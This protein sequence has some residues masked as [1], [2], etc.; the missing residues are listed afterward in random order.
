MPIINH[1]LK[2]WFVSPEPTTLFTWGIQ[3]DLEVK[4]EA[5]D[6]YQVYVTPH[7]IAAIDLPW[8]LL[9][10]NPSPR[11]VC[12]HPDYFPCTIVAIICGLMS[13]MISKKHSTL[14]SIL[15]DLE[16]GEEY[17]H[18]EDLKI[19]WILFLSLSNLLY[20]NNQI[21]K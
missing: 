5:N 1:N 9:N 12:R 20:I 4:S 3:P 15:T 21:N 17:H 11:S 6:R 13:H 19:T 14:P 2:K 10:S 18:K 16:L 8:Q 7:D